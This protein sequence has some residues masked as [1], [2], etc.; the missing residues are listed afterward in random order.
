MASGV[1]LIIKFD[2]FDKFIAGLPGAIGDGNEELA[3]ECSD[4]SA[5][6]A[7]VLSGALRDSHHVERHSDTEADA[8]AD[9]GHAL[10]VEMGTR[11][12]PAQPFMTPAGH[13]VASNAESHFV[14]RIEAL[15]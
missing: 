10:Y 13:S 7:P 3:Q 4:L 15:I 1:E 11:Y 6:N 8:V 5:E 9:A 2:H 12:M 14:G